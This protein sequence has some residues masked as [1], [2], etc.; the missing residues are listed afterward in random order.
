MNDFS[1][2]TVKYVRNVGRPGARTHYKTF[3]R[4]DYPLKVSSLSFFFINYNSFSFIRKEV[5]HDRPPSVPSH[6][7]ITK[8]RSYYLSKV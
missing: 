6:I 3:D 5:A 1:L 7:S 4:H 8:K 2:I